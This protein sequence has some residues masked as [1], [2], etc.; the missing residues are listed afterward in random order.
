[1]NEQHRS[2]LLDIVTHMS[3]S[4][5]KDVFAHMRDTENIRAT[6]FPRHGF[7][8]GEFAVAYVIHLPGKPSKKKGNARAVHDT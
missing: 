5:V 7:T 8:A 3:P 6:F 4:E 1:M 2:A